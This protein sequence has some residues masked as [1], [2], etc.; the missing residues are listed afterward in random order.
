M[1]SSTR[2]IQRDSVKKNAMENMGQKHSAAMELDEVFPER[3]RKVKLSDG[4]EYP[5]PIINFRT[6]G[7]LRKHFGSDS[8]IEALT[9]KMNWNNEEDFLFLVST[10]ISQEQAVS[11]EQLE[12]LVDLD[13]MQALMDALLMQVIS[14]M[15]TEAQQAINARKNEVSA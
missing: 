6:L 5:I 4:Q 7:I 9:Q 2:A 14:S 1:A 3:I 12:T 8:W 11:V 15:P 10:V 13:N